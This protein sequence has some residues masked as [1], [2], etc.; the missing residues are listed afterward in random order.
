MRKTPPERAGF[1]RARTGTRSVSPRLPIVRPGEHRRDGAGATTADRP[2]PFDAWPI[3]SAGHR[4]GQRLCPTRSGQT[5]AGRFAERCTSLATM[6]TAISDTEQ[7]RVRPDRSA[8]HRSRRLPVD[9]TTGLPGPLQGVARRHR[10]RRPPPAG[11]LCPAL[12]PI[13]E[14]AA[15]TTPSGTS[16]TADELRHGQVL[17]PAAGDPSAAH[18]PLTSLLL[19]AV[20]LRAGLPPGSRPSRDSPRPC[21]ERSSSSS[22]ACWVGTSPAAEWASSPPCWRRSAPDFWIPS[23]IVMSE[24]PAMLL[25]ALILLAIVRYLRSPGLFRAALIGVA[26]GAEALV[27]AELLLFV[28]TLLLPAILAARTVPFRRR[29]G[30]LGLALLA[31]ALVLAPWVGRNLTAFTDRTYISTGNGLALLGRELPADLLRTQLG[32]WVFSCAIRARGPGDESVQSARENPRRRPVRRSSSVP[33]AGRR[34]RPHRTRMGLLPPAQEAYIESGEGRPVPATNAGTAVY[35]VMLPLIRRRHRHLPPPAHPPVVPPRTGRRPHPGVRPRLRADPLPRSLR[36]VHGRPGRGADRPPRR[37]VTTPA[38]SIANDL[39]RSAPRPPRRR[40]TVTTGRAFVRL[41]RG[42]QQRS[43]PSP[44]TV[45]AVLVASA[46]PRAAS[47]GRILGA[48]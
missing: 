8:G 34:P 26:I 29:M 3:T 9:R 48:R 2:G 21:S 7:R 46:R 13:R 24:T 14:Q 44:G 35:Y 17:S 40:L 38:S 42:S 28:P 19:G 45:T 30:Q 4:P 43:P 31:T 47:C 12:H 11:G 20:N 22:S 41:G 18:P 36:G 33:A 5:G 10:H 37:T 23:G 39:Q 27:R 16:I 1:F 15:S 25:M 6:T 32:S